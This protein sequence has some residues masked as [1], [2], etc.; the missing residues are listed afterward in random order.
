M[1][2]DKGIER[3]NECFGFEGFDHIGIEGS[4]GISRGGS[5]TSY[6]CARGAQYN[7]VWAMR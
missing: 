2:Q 3:G 6:P 7:L 4:I 1:V 5:S